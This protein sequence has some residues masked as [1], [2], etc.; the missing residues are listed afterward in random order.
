MMI[1]NN[2]LA[3]ILGLSL[4]GV[5]TGASAA[6][7]VTGYQIN[8]GDILLVSVW[9]EPD[10]QG[11]AIVRP[12]GGISFPLVGDLTVQ[13][14]TVEN[15]RQLITG[16]LQKFIP[17]PVVTV[18]MKQLSGNKLYVIGKVNKPGVFPIDQTIDV[19]KALA[20]AGGLTPY[21]A[22]SGI[23]ILRREGKQQKVFPF[24]YSE[25]ESGEKLEQNRILV[26]GDVV[27]VP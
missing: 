25:V 6:D 19:M 2:Y 1:K 13:G 5:I 26:S 16:K 8:A 20:M 18:T 27:V 17:D 3:M 7:D 14:K 23:K 21:A 9:K 11:E 12:D 4:L 22:T 24:D 15:V 10:L